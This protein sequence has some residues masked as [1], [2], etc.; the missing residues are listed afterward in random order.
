[1]V[2][3]E[4]L[5]QSF[6]HHAQNAQGLVDDIGSNLTALAKGFESLANT[7]KDMASRQ[8]TDLQQQE[9]QRQAVLHELKGH[10]TT[11]GHI[12]SS[13]NHARDHLKNLV[14]E[15]HELR[16][17]QSKPDGTVS[18]DGESLLCTMN[19][20]LK[21]VGKAWN[22]MIGRLLSFWEGPFSGANW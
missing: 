4:R 7:L 2:K 18:K 21:V 1:M 5:N 10:Q 14:W 13:S 9:D 17:A 6:E 22:G 16:T 19:E 15:V 8:R 11:L 20:N 3:L 12:R